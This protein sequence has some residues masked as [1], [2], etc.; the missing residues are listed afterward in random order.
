MAGLIVSNIKKRP[1]RTVVSVLAVSISVMMILLF[2][3]LTQG[4]LKDSAD[5]T[6]NIKADIIF[7]PPDSSMLMA[8]NSTTMHIRF[9]ERLKQVEGIQFVSPMIHQFNK[10]GFSLIFGIDYSSFNQVSDNGLILLDGRTFSASYECLVD[11]IYQRSNHTKLGD[12]LKVLNHDF[13]VVG[14]FKAGI[15]ARILTPLATLQELAEQTDKVSLF[16]IKCKAP[17]DIDRVYQYLTTTPPFKG[18]NVTRAADIDSAFSSNLPGLKEFTIVIIAVAVLIS[19]LVILLT[20]YTTITERTREIGILKS[21][22]ASKSFIINLI[23]QESILLTF[24]GIIFGLI[25]CG[26]TI[27]ILARVYPSL[28]ILMQPVWVFYVTLL[29]LIS[30]IFGSFYPALRAARLD[31]VQA[32][33]YE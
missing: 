18:N 19:F 28:P 16:Y 24:F 9:G 1:T 5:R 8:L 32:L 27:M 15:G 31:P 12:Q 7:S 30:G 20:M 23:L 25:F 11:D 3:G 6:K 17:E 26:A 29:A 10:K 13:T 14:I 21:L 4:M 2:V 33:M 22:G